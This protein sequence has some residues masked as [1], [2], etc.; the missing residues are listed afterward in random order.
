[1]VDESLFGVSLK[2]EKRGSETCTNRSFEE[3]ICVLASLF[4]FKVIF[5]N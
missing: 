2:D 5:F 3:R 4:D 1:M